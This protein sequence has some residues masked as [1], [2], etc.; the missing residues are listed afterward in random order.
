VSTAPA[1]RDELLA[2][3][4]QLAEHGT[5][6]ADTAPYFDIGSRE[7]VDFFTEEILD[8]LIA[9]GGAT[10]RFFEGAYGSG[11]THLLQMLENA[12]RK[13]HL[14]VVRVDLSEALALHDWRL[15]TQYILQ[16]VTVE[17][18]GEVTRGLPNVL[19]RVG[20]FIPVNQHDFEL[21]QLPHPG[22]KTAMLQGC[23]AGSQDEEALVRFLN[24]ERVTVS[25]LQRSGIFGV[26]NPL[27]ARNAEQ[28]LN[29]LLAGL[30]RLGL[31]GTMLLFDENEKTFDSHVRYSY[32]RQL[33]VNLIR[34]FIDAC[35]TGGLVGTVAVFAM[36]PGF[37][38]AC[39]L[40]YPALGQRL[41][42]TRGGLYPP[43]WRWPVLPLEAVGSV[44]DPDEFLSE[45]VEVFIGL[46]S[47]HI[48]T[49]DG[50]DARLRH[51]GKS[52]LEADAGTG[53]RRPLIKAL[54]DA[55]LN[56]L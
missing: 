10:C 9:P 50:M 43:A 1:T 45:A 6:P 20:K 27:S 4:E 36:L 40:E 15:I 53:Y 33:A 47:E 29:T 48:P 32:R 37:L 24:G 39:A 12:G 8:G 51:E 55:A 25:A 31:P 22:F 56:G 35:F 46:C 23:F 42:I 5:P 49:V 14:A 41:Q 54:A 17:F 30:H 2:L 13:R 21:A 11:K 19:E 28:V 26:K 18:G 52:V 34:R 38:E 16:N 3:L 44:T 7:F